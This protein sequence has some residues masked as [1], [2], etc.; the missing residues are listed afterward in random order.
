MKKRQENTPL[1]RDFSSTARSLGIG[2]SLLYQMDSDGRLGPKKIRFGRRSLLDTEE[3]ADW[4][5]AGTPCRDVWQKMK[6]ER[7]Q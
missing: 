6:K 3:I 2:K 1:L 4:V 7:R 5:R